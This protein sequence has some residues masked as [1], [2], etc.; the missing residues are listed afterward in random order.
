MD[1]WSQRSGP[2]SWS[3]AQ[4]LPGLLRLLKWKGIGGHHP[5]ELKGGVQEG[6][7]AVT[8]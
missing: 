4:G 1:R 5:G 6:H 8:T 2:C 7:S 3:K